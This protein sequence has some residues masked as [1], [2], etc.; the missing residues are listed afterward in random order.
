MID[1]SKRSG[2][3]V[4]RGYKEDGVSPDGQLWKNYQRNM[5]PLDRPDSRTAVLIRI[6]RDAV[7]ELDQLGAFVEMVALAQHQ[8]GVH[9]QDI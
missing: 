6:A 3:P 1:E 7:R 2:E 8:T 5:I 4:N 9:Y